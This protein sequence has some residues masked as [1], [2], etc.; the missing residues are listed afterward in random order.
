MKLIDILVRDLHKFGGWPEG[1]VECHRFVDEA[2]IDFYDVNGQWDDDCFLKY[3]AFA[4]EAV[5]E[6]VSACESES[7]SHAQYEA[8][9][10]S[11]KPEWD[12]VGLPP[13]G[14][15]CEMS[16]AGDEWHKCVI[17]AKGEEQIIYQTQGCREFSGHRNNYR[18]RPI[19]SEAE[20]KRDA[21]A[22]AIDY[23][24]PA[25]P[26]TQN[27]FYHAKKLYDAIAAGKIPH[28]RID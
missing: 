7:V 12:G 25:L 19:R 28:I 20:R 17:I 9:I 26:P 21:A 2:N 22:E 1:A 6:R 3:G 4:Q 8:A 27:K 13:V 18:F 14:V 23:W 16:Y 5:R 11:S 15:E 24:M 10:A